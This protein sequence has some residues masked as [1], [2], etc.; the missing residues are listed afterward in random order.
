MVVTKEEAKEM[1]CPA[2]D[3][4]YCVASDC[5][6]W[7]W[8]DD[9]KGLRDASTPRKGFCGLAGYPMEILDD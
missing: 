2:P 4:S 7:R 6:G 3:R 5:M 8:E 9:G 1:N